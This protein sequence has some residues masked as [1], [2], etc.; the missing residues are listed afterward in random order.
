MA[1]PSS[2]R[3]T[4]PSRS[5]PTSPTRPPSTATSCLRPLRNRMRRCW[6]STSV[7]R[8]SASMRSRPV[9]VNS[10]SPAS[11]T[12][13]C[14][15]ARSR[16]RVCSPCSTRSSTTCRRRWT[17][18]RSRDTFLV[19]KTR[20]SNASLRRTSRSLRW[21]SRSPCTRSLASSPTCVCTRA[22]SSPAR[23]S[24]MPPRARRSVWASC[25]RCTPTKKTRSRRPPR[26]TSTRSSA[27]RTPP[28]VTPCAIRTA[29][30]CWSP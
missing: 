19:T 8:N 4:R 3:A 24:S 11:C 25:S 13:C 6:R 29:R 22:R 18:S 12:R 5:P 7:A 27:S 28:P 10:P 30:S 1:R 21:L 15:V 20:R 23:R 9:S 17:S 2:A 26:V 14:A 16:T